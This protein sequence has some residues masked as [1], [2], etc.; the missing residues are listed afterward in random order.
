MSQLPG[1][2]ETNKRSAHQK[3]V[4]RARLLKS[5]KCDGFDILELEVDERPRLLRNQQLDQQE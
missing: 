2:G 4:R 5:S 3:S 1:T